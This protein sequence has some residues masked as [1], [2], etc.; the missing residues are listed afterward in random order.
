MSKKLLNAMQLLN[1]MFISIASMMVY[2]A[3]MPASNNLQVISTQP[4]S[5][6][7]ERKD[8]SFNRLFTT[9]QQRQIL[10]EW[11]AHGGLKKSHVSGTDENKAD[12]EIEPVVDPGQPVK[13]SG[14][15]MRADGRNAVWLNGSLEKPTE[16]SAH[17]IR[18]S[19]L[20]SASVKVPLRANEPGAILKPGQVWVP[21]GQQVKE[22]YQIPQP[23]AALDIS[24]AASSEANASN[25]Q[26]SVNSSEMSANVETK[27][28]AKS[29]P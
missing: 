6:L 10:D 24:S 20:Q 29:K 17:T 18:G 3:E 15:L 5:S 25:A 26:S 12:L 7:A 9:P 23:K 28:S 11:R 1:G 16:G 14:I 27:T 22:A 19:K 13:L 21:D 2:S 8:E 4:V